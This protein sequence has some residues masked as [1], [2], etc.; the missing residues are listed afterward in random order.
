MMVC[1][2]GSSIRYEMAP[3]SGWVREKESPARSGWY[4]TMNTARETRTVGIDLAAQ[5]KKT[6]VCVVDWVDS[7]A[8]VEVLKTSVDDDEILELVTGAGRVGIDAPLGWPSSFV[9]GVV[10]HAE[11]GSWDDLTD[12]GTEPLR[13]RRTDVWVK[14]ETNRAPLSVSTDRL[15]VAAIRCARLLAK[16]QLRLQQ[17]VDRTGVA[18]PWVEV[19]PRAALQRWGLLTVPY[20]GVGRDSALSDLVDTLC[21]KAPWLEV[22]R[23]ELRKS[24]DLFD[25]VIC[26][27]VARAAA[28]N[29]T[30][31]IPTG[32]LE[33][34]RTEG[35][36]HLPEP[37]SLEVLSAP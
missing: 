15:G 25:A 11:H 22:D 4:D 14:A 29:L 35:W 19:Y 32:E 21:A 1:V 24:D 16:W 8:V 5:T 34:A 30:S 6:G 27:L 10:S 37:Y 2:P 18:G 13:L 9:T 26:A 31:P 3:V 36:I 23:Y 7:A 12:Q 20:K 17:G 28:L 33:A